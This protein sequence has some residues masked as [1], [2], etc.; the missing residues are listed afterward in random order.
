MWHVSSHEKVMRRAGSRAARK[1]EIMWHVRCLWK[2]LPLQIERGAVGWEKRDA[3]W[4]RTACFDFKHRDGLKS[5]ALFLWKRERAGKSCWKTPA[6]PFEWVFHPSST[7]FLSQCSSFLFF[8]SYVLFCQSDS[9]CI[10]NYQSVL[11]LNTYWDPCLLQD[12]IKLW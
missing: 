7:K 2:T 6:A 3:L 8:F 12:L 4:I 9:T 5:D 11:F 1:C 10:D